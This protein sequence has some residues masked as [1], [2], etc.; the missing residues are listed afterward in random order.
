MGGAGD[1][2]VDSHAM[3][4]TRRSSG[5]GTTCGQRNGLWTEPSENGAE[6][7]RTWPRLT[8]GRSHRQPTTR[9]VVQQHPQARPALSEVALALAELDHNPLAGDPALIE[10]AAREVIAVRPGADADD[11]LLWAASLRHHTATTTTTTDD[12]RRQTA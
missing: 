10:Q 3:E 7:V 1:R 9:P 4:K 2:M 11:V 6:L 5:P 12:D 8:S